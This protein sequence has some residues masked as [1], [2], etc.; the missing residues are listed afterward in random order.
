M[1]DGEDAEDRTLGRKVIRGGGQAELGD[2]IGYLDGDTAE[3]FPC[4]CLC[5]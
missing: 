4:L 1:H 5:L 3:K 2:F